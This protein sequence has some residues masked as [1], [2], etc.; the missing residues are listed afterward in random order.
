MQPRGAR[1]GTASTRRAGSLTPAGRRVSRV[2]ASR[3]YRQTR[4]GPRQRDRPLRVRPCLL[5][6]RVRLEQ[7]QTIRPWA[8]EVER[9]AAGDTPHGQTEVVRSTADR[10]GAA[11]EQGRHEG[12]HKAILTRTATGSRPAKKAGS[13]L[14]QYRGARTERMQGGTAKWRGE[15]PRPGVGRRPPGQGMTGRRC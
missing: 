9:L 2:A 13:P 6:R 14:Y 8:A 3:R 4:G 15:S 11:S 5:A 1:R 12:S 10:A 7:A